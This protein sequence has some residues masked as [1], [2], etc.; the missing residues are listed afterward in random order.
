[1][2]R[3]QNSFLWPENAPP[4]AR[5]PHMTEAAAVGVFRLELSHAAEG[6]TA[7]ILFR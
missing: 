6:A 1:M 3:P 5:A 4:R 7:H 2:T